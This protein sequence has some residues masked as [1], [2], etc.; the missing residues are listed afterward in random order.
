M[1]T[2]CLLEASLTVMSQLCS[3]CLFF[4]HCIFCFIVKNTFVRKFSDRHPLNHE[5]RLFFQ[6]S[7]CMFLHSKKYVHKF[8]DRHPLNHEDR[9]FFQFFL[10]MFLPQALNGLPQLC[11]MLVVQL[12]TPVDAVWP[13][14]GA[15]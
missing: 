9:L 12:F 7:L 11:E 13:T 6:F 8:L 2:A 3:Q 15:F 14:F 5:D 4:Q 1:F 10:C